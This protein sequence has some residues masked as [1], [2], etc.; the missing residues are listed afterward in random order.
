SGPAMSIPAVSGP[1]VSGPA[2]SGPAVSGPAVP[3]SNLG[4]AFRAVP[5]PLPI[6]VIGSRYDMAVVTAVPGARAACDARAGAS[7]WIRRVEIGVDERRIAQIR[8][9]QVCFHE[10][11]AGEVGARE[12]G[13]F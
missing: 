10:G 11:C 2:V 4:A 8:P 1:A 13:A 3:A 12:I 7:D 5:M 9:G 6:A